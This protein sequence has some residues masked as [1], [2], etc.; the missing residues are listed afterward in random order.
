MNL[1]PFLAAC[2]AAPDVHLTHFLCVTPE[3]IAAQY[4]APLYRMDTLRLDFQINVGFT[5]QDFSVLG[6]REV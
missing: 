3:G 4:A 6:T 5:M 2:G 1:S